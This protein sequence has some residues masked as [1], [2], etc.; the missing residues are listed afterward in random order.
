MKKL[1]ELYDC[2]YDITI[3]DIKLNSKEVSNGDLFVCTKGSI[4]D[5][6]DFIDEAIKNV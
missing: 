3:K 4:V 1:N 2:N 5:R 6:H